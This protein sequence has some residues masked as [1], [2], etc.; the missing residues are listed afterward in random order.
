MRNLNTKIIIITGLAATGKSWLANIISESTGLPLI[1]KDDIKIELFSS[2][3]TQDRAWDRKLG[4]TALNLQKL[5]LEKMLEKKVS[6]IVESNYLDQYDGDR[7][8]EL[9]SS[10]NVEYLQIVLGTDGDTLV[11]RYIKRATSGEK[12]EFFNEQNNIEEFSHRLKEGYVAP[13]DLPGKI[14]K[15][16]TTDFS[17]VNIEQI[18]SDVASFLTDK[19]LGVALNEGH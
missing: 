18:K 12:H 8:R 5:V 7:F 2:L 11:K 1:T 10:F 9:A 4:I 6:I 17:K 13:M 15:V 16:D 3:G 14:I 19:Y